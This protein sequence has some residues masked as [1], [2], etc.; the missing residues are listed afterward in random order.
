M[1]SISHWYGGRSV[2]GTSGRVG[3]VFDPA[4]GVQTGEVAL[5]SAGEVD[6]VVKVARDA[7]REW[8]ASPL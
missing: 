1:Q 8:A 6:E 7:A 5:A 3:P 2:T 4:R